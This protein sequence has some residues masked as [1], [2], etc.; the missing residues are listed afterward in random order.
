MKSQAGW[1]SREMPTES[2]HQADW[3]G[4]VNH[5]YFEFLLA[6]APRWVS[7]SGS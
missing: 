1:L 5:L 2:A 4:M 3:S 7:F 6:Q